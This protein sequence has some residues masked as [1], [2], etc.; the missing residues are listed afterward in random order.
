MTTS[1]L[2]HERMRE[3]GYSKIRLQ[4]EFDWINC[5]DEEL[6]DARSNVTRLLDLAKKVEKEF[7][8]I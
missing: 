6:Q 3:K 1:R 2:L 8:K 5:S 4:N 7:K